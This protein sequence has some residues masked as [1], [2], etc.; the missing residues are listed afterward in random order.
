MRITANGP[1]GL[2]E[3]RRSFGIP[4][5]VSELVILNNDWPPG[6]RF[7]VV[8]VAGSDFFTCRISR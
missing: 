4:P 5:L 6:S 1:A 2:G 7:C 3:I 8:A